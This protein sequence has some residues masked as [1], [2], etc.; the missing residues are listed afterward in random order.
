MTFTAREL[1]ALVKGQLIGDGDLTIQSARTL[2]DAQPGDITFVENKKNAPRL[3][4][5]QASAA[6]VPTNLTFPGKTLIQVADPLVAFAVV[7]QHFQAK[8]PFEPSGID[9]RA[10][11]HPDAQIGDDASVGPFTCI[12]AG[13]MI[14]QRCRLHN[15]VSIGK[16]CRIGDDVEL[17]PGVVLYD[18]T[19]LGDRV[20]LHANAVIGA[21]G[22][23]YR[24]QKGRYVKVPQL[25][26]VII[27]SDVEIGAG[28]CV[29][30]GVFEPTRI[31]EGTKI[32]NMVQIAHNCQIG[33]HN[34]FAAQV[35][36]GGSS[37]TGNYVVMGGQAG[38]SDHINIGEGSMFGAKTGVFQ[39]VPA[40]KRMF[41]YPAHEERE[42]GRILVCMRKLP[43]MR[44]DLLRILKELNLQETPERNSIRAAEAPAA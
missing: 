20:I 24:F 4:H 29:D 31:G 26:N 18:D 33:K 40:G 2:Q 19:V 43:M 35:G 16:N 28:S 30:R 10:V 6:I 1:S 37:T 22:F 14:G 5:S 12:G 7:F 21:D 32:D 23:G 9:P 8:P 27:G 39:D 34:A 13:T 38:V 41:L 15:G 17:H 25:S 3:E 11:L 42:S 44:K 36:I